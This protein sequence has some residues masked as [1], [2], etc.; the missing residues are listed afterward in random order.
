MTIQSGTPAAT[1][2]Q[3]PPR[4]IDTP[5]LLTR[6]AEALK[7]KSGSDLPLSCFVEQVKLQLAGG[8][9]AEELS[10]RARSQHSGARTDCYRAWAMPE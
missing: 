2:V 3:Q 10:R 6:L 4:P 5:E 1:G 9:S 7:A 8:L